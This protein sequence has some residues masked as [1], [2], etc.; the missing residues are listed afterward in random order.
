MF[1]IVLP[2]LITSLAFVLAACSAPQP[3]PAPAVIQEDAQP[4]AG[5]RINVRVNND[6]FDWD[7]STGG[8]TNPNSH[9]IAL[10][11]NSLLGFKK[12]VEYSDMIVQPELAERWE[13]S[14]DSRSF[15]FHLRKDVKFANLPPVNGRGLTSAD[16][17]WS[18]EYWN[19]IGELKDKKLP[20]GQHE[21]MYEGLEAV[22]AP[23]PQTLVIRFSEPFAPFLSYAASEW[24]PVVPREIFERDGNFKDTIAGTGPFTLDALTSQKGSRWVWK[25][26]PNYFEQGRPYLDEVRWI[27][28]GE[29]AT[30]YAGF[31]T[32]QL[33]LLYNVAFNDAQDVMKANPQ[34]QFKEYMQPIGYRIF[35]SQIR[36]GPL[37]DLRVRKALDLSIDRDEILKVVSG[38]KGRWSPTAAFP[39]LFTDAEVK[40]M[41]KFDPVEAK[42]LLTEAG[43]SNGIDLEWIVVRDESQS[44]LAW[45]QL[46]Q[47]QIK[48]TGF[49]AQFRLL[50]RA[51][52]RQRKYAGDYDLDYGVGLGTV[53]ADVD[54]VIFAPH[55]SASSYN[56]QKMNDPELDKLLIGQRR[57]PNPEKRRE[58]LR[59]AVR[60]LVEQSWTPYLIYP[61]QWD[62][63]HPEVRGYSPHFSS[64]VNYAAAWL[65]K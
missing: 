4:K 36:K 20:A 39:D 3:A 40:Q 23:N 34:A 56:N 15:T 50:E 11:Y 44:N 46:V 19:R 37:N 31:Q 62:F 5:G 18:V 25:K 58:I 8:K 12:N 6:P 14:S 55:H 1:R 26:N 30:A 49:N 2:F 47:A 24:N 54:S 7:M 9:G 17:K 42:R 61:P 52:Q 16:A 43:Y 59:S 53:E 21:W 48:K 65:D 29:E 60:R 27:V 22:E 63:W 38:G 35:I 33:D 28:L 32:K 45:M 10:S 57:E 51:A 64:R 13:V 41:L